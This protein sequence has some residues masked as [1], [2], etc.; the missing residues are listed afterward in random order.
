MNNAVIVQHAQ[1]AGYNRTN[2]EMR[3]LLKLPLAAVIRM[4]K[5]LM[6]KKRCTPKYP[7]L[8]TGANSG[9]GMTVMASA[10]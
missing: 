1:N 7:Y 8:A 3:K 9:Y 2:L 5:P 6:M 10:V 4:T